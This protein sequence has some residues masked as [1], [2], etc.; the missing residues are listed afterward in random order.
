MAYLPQLPGSA[1]RVPGYSLVNARVTYTSE[2]DEV[3]TVT[4]GRE[5]ARQVLLVPA[6]PVRSNVDGS[7]SDNATGA[8]ARPRQVSVSFRRHFD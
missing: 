8:P 7:A 6:R 1:N 3:V 4:V 5:P 2:D